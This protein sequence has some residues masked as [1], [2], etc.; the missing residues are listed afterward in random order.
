LWALVR[1]QAPVREQRV[2]RR[3]TARVRHDVVVDVLENNGKADVMGERLDDRRVVP[4]GEQ[5][6]DELDVEPLELG[7]IRF[8]QLGEQLVDLRRHLDEGDLVV[9][10]DEREAQPVGLV[11]QG[12]RH[13]A[14]R[15]SAQLDDERHR[16]RLADLADVLALGGRG[17]ADAESRGE[18]H[19]ATDQEACDVG[20]LDR[21]HP[22]DVPVEVLVAGEDAH[23]RPA[24][25][26]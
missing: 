20:N 18:Q 15:A 7:E 19:L 16:A 13:G 17:R 6:L 11:D 1:V 12:R 26:L 3:R 10:A 22:A 9:Q 24:E 8:P 2:R 23:R 5:E 4:A 25:R 14:E 21:M